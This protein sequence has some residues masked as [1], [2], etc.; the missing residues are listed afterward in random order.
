MLKPT[1]KPKIGL[2]PTG[3]KM[4][5]EQ[6]PGLREMGMR[7]Y[8]TLVKSLETFGDVISTGL[9]DDFESASASAELFKEN[10]IDILLIFPFGYTT[11][12][13]IVPALKVIDVPIRLLN[14]HEDAN[15]DFKRGHC[16]VPSS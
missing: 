8:G 14:A 12:M 11:G 7:M 1:V 6:Y 13:M 4:Y 3:H 9:A 5:W 16:H 2:L 10:E 15:Y